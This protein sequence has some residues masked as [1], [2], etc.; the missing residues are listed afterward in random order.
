MG[1]GLGLG[2]AVGDEDLGSGK[3]PLP[4]GELPTNV[5]TLSC[6]SST[7]PLKVLLPEKVAC[8]NDATRTPPP[9][10]MFPERSTKLWT[11]GFDRTVKAWELTPPTAGDVNRV[12]TWLQVLSGLEL[13]ADGVFREL[14]ASA[15]LQRRQLLTDLGGPP[16]TDLPIR[17]ARVDTS[18]NRPSRAEPSS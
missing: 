7:P 12:V 11:A 15:W 4:S 10:V 13:D 17:P 14:N 3:G 6:R 1:Y 5:T 9:P 8:A 16:N 18:S 2:G